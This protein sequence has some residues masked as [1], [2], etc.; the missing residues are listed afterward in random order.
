MQIKDS[1]LDYTTLGHT[2]LEFERATR[3]YIVVRHHKS[4]AQE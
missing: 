2:A 3:A 1:L 4:R